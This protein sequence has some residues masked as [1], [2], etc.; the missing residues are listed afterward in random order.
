MK[1]KRVSAEEVARAMKAIY[2]QMDESS[3]DEVIALKLT[4]AANCTKAARLSDEVKRLNREVKRLERE[5][6][7]AL[8]EKSAV[9]DYN[10]MLAQRLKELSKENENLKMK[11]YVIKVD[12]HTCGKCAAFKE[13]ENGVGA[14][15]ASGRGAPT[16]D[17][18]GWYEMTGESDTCPYWSDTLSDA[19]QKFR[20][21]EG[22]GKR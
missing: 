3:N 14:C 15:L 19:I 2:E 11:L 17:I 4:N 9:K 8:T 7:K 13:I 22:I 10:K 5:L 16:A 21:G 1:Q 20:E 6:E 12:S 18:R